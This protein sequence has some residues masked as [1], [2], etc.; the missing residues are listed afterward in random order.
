MW[1]RHC[2]LVNLFKTNRYLEGDDDYSG[3]KSYRSTGF[4]GWSTR[5]LAKVK[6]ELTILQPS[7]NVISVVE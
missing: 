7:G 1:P 6:F 5:D 3:G 2:N 4:G